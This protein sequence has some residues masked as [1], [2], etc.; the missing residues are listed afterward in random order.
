METAKDHGVVFNST[1][2]C[3]RQHQIAI[4]GTVF[5][6]QGMWPDPTKIQALQDLPI[7]NCQAKIQSFLGLINYLQAFTP[8]MSTKTTFLSEQLTEWDWNPSTDAA[9]QH[10][11]AWILCTMIDSS[12][13]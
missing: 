10:L 9:F 7:P 4:Y 2:C 11:K 3:I 13:S 8:G 6:A 12:L 5:T 1:K